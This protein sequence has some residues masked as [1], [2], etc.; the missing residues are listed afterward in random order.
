MKI[1]TATVSVFC[2]HRASIQDSF[3]CVKQCS[4]IDVTGVQNS[5]SVSTGVRVA[6]QIFVSCL[7]FENIYFGMF[8]NGNGISKE[9]TL[10]T[11]ITEVQ[12]LLLIV[13]K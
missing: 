8:G 1:W 10:N 12:R 6:Y 11:D 13:T 5:N 7:Y 9:Y 4:R 3:F 2:R